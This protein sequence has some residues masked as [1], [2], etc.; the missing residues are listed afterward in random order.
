[1]KKIVLLVVMLFCY[2]KSGFAYDDKVC[3]PTSGTPTKQSFQ[4]TKTLTK[5]QNTANSTIVPRTE[6]T[7]TGS[8]SFSCYCTSP[9]ATMVHWWSA[10][11]M[12]PYTAVSGQYWQQ[13]TPNLAAS[14]EIYVYGSTGGPVV[15]SYHPVPFTGVANI[16]SEKCGITNGN[17]TS[18]SRG[19]VSVKITKPSV[20]NIT[21][22]GPVAKIWH[23]RKANYYN[24]ADPVEAVVNLNLNITIPGGCT[25]LQGSVLNIDL[26]G[27]TR[28]TQFIDRP[29]P[30][31]P[32]SYTP[33]PVDLKFDCDFA[34][35]DM[36]VVLTGD[37]D[38][39]GKG[40]A[41]SSPDVSVIVTDTNGTIIP[42]NTQAG[43]VSIDATSISSTLKLKA[44]P[45]NSGSQAA[46]E[47][48]PYN[49]TATILLSYE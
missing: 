9:N 11:A 41:T 10:R 31:A 40:F 34:N 22:N 33:R 13:L 12:F 38:E 15:S 36:D 28:Q 4:I 42:P 7:S 32:S 6:T 29:Y 39:Q 18:G 2:V 1:M 37:T 25:L 35:S 14:V 21:F 27:Q 26:G 43:S 16:S 8:T 17:A 49:A 44:Y 20:G 30:S 47:A 3:Y 24:P 23:Y 5:E 45:A 48:A 19:A 46:P